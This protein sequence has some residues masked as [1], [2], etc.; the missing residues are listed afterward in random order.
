[1]NNLTK[2]S[3]KHEKLAG[4]RENADRKIHSLNCLKNP[5]K[6]TPWYNYYDGFVTDQTLNGCMYL[7]DLLVKSGALSGMY[8]F[9]KAK[10]CYLTRAEKRQLYHRFPALVR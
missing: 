5:K 7:G 2:A 4:S 8:F 6:L 9:G 1:M 10:F 3:K